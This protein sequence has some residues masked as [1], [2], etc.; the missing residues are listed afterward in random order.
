MKVKTEF[1]ELHCPFCGA[2][3]KFT[4]TEKVNLSKVI[5]FYCPMYRV[6]VFL[7]GRTYEDVDLSFLK[8]RSRRKSQRVRGEIRVGGK[9]F[10]YGDIVE[11]S[12]EY[13]NYPELAKALGVDPGE[14]WDAIYDAK[15][16]YNLPFKHKGP[17]P[18]KKGGKYG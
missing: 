5:G 14:L 9:T 2:T 16:N 12:K 15:Q 18:K 7:Y 11:K 3:H 6:R 4:Y 10:E 13:A 17:E 1:R 8:P